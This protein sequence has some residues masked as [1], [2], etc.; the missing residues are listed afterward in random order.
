MSRELGFDPLGFDGAPQG[1]V[2]R[3]RETRMQQS[4]EA[5][6]HNVLLRG[7]SLV[8]RR[9]PQPVT[10]VVADNGEPL[11]LELRQKIAAARAARLAEVERLAVRKEWLFG[12]TVYYDADGN[13]LSLDFHTDLTDHAVEELG[14]SAQKAVERQPAMQIVQPRELELP[15]IKDPL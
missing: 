8:D 6:R 3:V 9:N 14:A 2:Q 10:G 1:Q 15:T 12:R 13:E 5:Y 11:T 4:I 7:T